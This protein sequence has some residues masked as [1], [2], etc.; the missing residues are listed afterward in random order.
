[1]EDEVRQKLFETYFLQHRLSSGSRAERLEAD[2]HFWAWELVERTV[3]QDAEKGW[4]LILGLIAAAATEDEVGFVAAGPLEDLIHEHGSEVVE[5]VEE[6]AR[7]DSDFRR[8]LAGVVAPDDEAGAR[9][10]R[11]LGRNRRGH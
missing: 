7:L 8:A 9:I 4:D 3:H 2:Q 10:D 5:W 11:L 1:M 6:R